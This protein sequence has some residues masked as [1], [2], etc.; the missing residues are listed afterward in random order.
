VPSCGHGMCNCIL[1]SHLAISLP[2]TICFSFWKMLFSQIILLQ[3]YYPLPFHS[4]S[5]YLLKLYEN[6]WT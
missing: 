6:N 5:R 1:T 2:V 3:P 4:H